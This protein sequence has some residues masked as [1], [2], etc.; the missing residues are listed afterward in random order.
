MSDPPT[1]LF[2][3][4]FESALL[5]Y[6]KQTGTRLTEHPLAQQL[7]NCDSIESATAILHEHAGAFSEFRRSDGRIMKSLKSVVSVLHTLS[8]SSVLGVAIDLVLPI[9]MMSIF[10]SLIL[11]LFFSHSRLRMQYLPVLPCYLRCVALS[12]PMCAS[13]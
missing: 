4:L 12:N 9:D 6:E 7:E 8:T 3:A 13:L 1:P 5:D 11:I 2:A 10:S